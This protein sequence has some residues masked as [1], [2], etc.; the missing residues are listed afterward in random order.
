MTGRAPEQDLPRRGGEGDHGEGADEQ[1]AARTGPDVLRSEAEPGQDIGSGE[2]D[3][4][5]DRELFRGL[6]RVRMAKEAEERE[7]AEWS[8]VFLSFRWPTLVF[9]LAAL[10]YMAY[11]RSCRVA[12]E[13]PDPVSA[14]LDRGQRAAVTI[15]EGFR[16]GRITQTF[17][18]A[19]PRLVEGSGMSLE[20]AAFEATE[21]L[22]RT[23]ERRVLWDL[24]DL[25]TNE[26]EIRVPVTYR[27]NV[28]LDADWSLDVRDHACIVRAPAIRATL[29]PAIHTD[30]MEKRSTR[31]W[32]RFDVD[33]QM[34][35]LE[36]SI[37]PTLSER[38]VRRET[39]ELVRETARRRVGEFVQR[40]LVGEDHWR[41]DRFRSVTVIFA[42]EAVADGELPDPTAVLIEGR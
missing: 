14:A 31:G 17:V 21:T 37:T 8:R 7:A 20:V 4:P 33:E 3:P 16:R 11:V 19:I 39:I 9:A 22:S 29:P 41:E 35:E 40:W 28:P 6:R 23:D 2:G 42:D 18:A 5:A 12:A 38:A 26:T 34:E 32:L 30:R 10:S 27:Y 1:S 15:A 25:G 13:S 36:R 24:V